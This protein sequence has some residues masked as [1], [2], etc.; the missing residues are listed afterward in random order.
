MMVL[1][2]VRALLVGTTLLGAS[3]VVT[4]ERGIRLIER[5]GHHVGIA[6]LDAVAPVARLRPV[7]E[8]YATIFADAGRTLRF[9]HGLGGIGTTRAEQPGEDVQRAWRRI[10]TAGGA[11]GLTMGSPPLEAAASALLASVAD[12]VNRGILIPGTGVMLRRLFLDGLLSIAAPLTDRIADAGATG[13]RR[14]HITGIA[15]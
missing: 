10:Y 12:I 2:I 3:S 14:A 15:A 7:F 9:E 11:P 6:N 5:A 8:D 13:A 1:G 4:T